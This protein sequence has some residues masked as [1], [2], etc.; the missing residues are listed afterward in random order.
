[1]GS[2]LSRLVPAPSGPRNDP[3]HSA[4]R[5]WLSRKGSDAQSEA[6]TLAY[7]FL[8]GGFQI[9]LESGCGTSCQDVGMLM[10]QHSEHASVTGFGTGSD[11]SEIEVCPMELSLCQV[12]IQSSSVQAVQVSC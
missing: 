3:L 7:P 5:L 11:Y 1:M 2:I 9:L 12:L 6:L 10:T 4:G 8:T